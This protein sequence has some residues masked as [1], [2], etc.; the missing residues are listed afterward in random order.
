MVS[1]CKAKAAWMEKREKAK[2][3]KDAA[4]DPMLQI[5]EKN[6]REIKRRWL[7]EYVREKERTLKSGAVM[8]GEEEDDVDVHGEDDDMYEHDMYERERSERKKKLPNDQESWSCPTT[9][10]DERKRAQRQMGARPGLPLLRSP[11]GS[12]AAFAVLTLLSGTTRRTRSG[13]RTTRG[14]ITPR[15]TTRTPPRSTWT[16]IAWVCTT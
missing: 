13:T 12:P 11:P 4:E 1:M 7:E 8:G 15:W 2:E 14:R 16:A 5:M 10:G 9:N 6:G 3:D